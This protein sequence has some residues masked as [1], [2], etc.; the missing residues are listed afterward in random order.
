VKIKTISLNMYLYPGESEKWNLDKHDFIYIKSTGIIEID[1]NRTKVRLTSEKSGLCQYSHGQFSVLNSDNHPVCLQIIKFSCITIILK[2]FFLTDFDPSPY[3]SILMDGQL[4]EDYKT[5]IRSLLEKYH[6]PT[7]TSEKREQIDTRLIQLN[8]FI[9]KNFQSNITLQDLAEY[10]GVHPT[11]LCN[12]YSKVFKISPIY[13]MNQ[14]RINNAK[15]LLIQTDLP[16]KEI[17]QF[18]GYNS[19]SQFSSIFKRYCLK[20]P[21]QYRDEILESVTSI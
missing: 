20:T 1:L 21:S 14:L 8:R 3:D 2:D 5:I 7:Q 17:A 9:R 19:L 4:S 18:V 12:M 11:Y 16:I 6:K 15:E 10:V 13:F